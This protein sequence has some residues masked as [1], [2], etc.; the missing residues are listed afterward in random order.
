VRRLQRAY[1]ELWVNVLTKVDPTLSAE[2][3]RTRAHATFGLLNS[4]P[5][6]AAARDAVAV[7]P[8]LIRMARAALA[9]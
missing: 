5:H 2:D 9:V 6:S 3:A 7:G 4:T 8:T 1:V